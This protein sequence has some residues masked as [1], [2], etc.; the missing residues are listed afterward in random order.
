[1][2]NSENPS[3]LNESVSHNVYF[4]GKVQ[5]LGLETTKGK[6][7]V[8]VMKK[9]TYTFSASSPEQMVIVSGI[10]QVKLNGA[11]FKAY[12]EQDNF[13][14]AAGTSFDIICDDDVA[15]IC[16]YG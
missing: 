14:V 3:E 5:S 13:H 12:K 7:T 10:M 1:M 15:Y 8:G 2:S 11:D 6:A 16:Y 4:E 9:G